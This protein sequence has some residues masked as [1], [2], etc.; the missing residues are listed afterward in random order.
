MGRIARYRAGSS[1]DAEVRIVHFC[2][3][4]TWSAAQAIGEYRADSLPTEGFV[5]CSAPEQVHLPA[6][7][8]ARGRTDL[9]LLEIQAD[10]LSAPVRWEPADP[11]DPASMRFPHVYGPIPV[12]AVVEVHDFPPGSDGTFG[13]WEPQHPGR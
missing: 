9:V 4:E 10:R 8:I 6:N 12:D 13:P 11:G 7:A 5:H 1:Y 2:P 3:R